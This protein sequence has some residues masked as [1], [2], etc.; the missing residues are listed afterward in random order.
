MNLKDNFYWFLEAKLLYNY[1]V[2][3]STVSKQSLLC[4]KL[5]WQRERE[6]TIGCL[7]RKSPKFY[8]RYLM[9]WL[10]NFLLNFDWL[11]DLIEFPYA[12]TTNC[13]LQKG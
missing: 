5:C 11:V 7:L 12:S 8:K 9:R 1:V 4:M 10:I 3:D 6:G 2:S 13:T